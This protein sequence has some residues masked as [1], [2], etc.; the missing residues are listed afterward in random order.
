MLKAIEDL[1]KHV[2]NE[3]LESFCL[4]DMLNHAVLYNFTILG[5]ALIHV[6]HEKLVNYNYPWY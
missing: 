6:E 2:Q 1:E 5:E 3:S 4:K